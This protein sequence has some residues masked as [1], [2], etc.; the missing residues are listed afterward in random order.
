MD[1]E[2]RLWLEARWRRAGVTYKPAGTGAKSA[3]GQRLEIEPRRLPRQD[4]T[5]ETDKDDWPNADETLSS[6][7]SENSE[8]EQRRM[9][10]HELSD[11]EM[12]HESLGWTN[13]YE[14]MRIAPE[15]DWKD[16][17]SQHER[18]YDF[19]DLGNKLSLD[20]GQETD[21]EDWTNTIPTMLLPPGIATTIAEEAESGEPSL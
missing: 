7:R 4:V 19:Y 18:A 14:P 13:S 6:A 10:Q 2:Q 15:Q 21:E 16:D 9:L 8:D 3:P 20:L 1:K 5:E 12:I 11:K 17:E